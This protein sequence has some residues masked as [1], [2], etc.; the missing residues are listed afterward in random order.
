MRW[1]QQVQFISAVPMSQPPAAAIGTTV[2]GMWASPE[3]RSA[4]AVATPHSRGQRVLFSVPMIALTPGV[5]HS[6]ADRHLLHEVCR[7]IDGDSGK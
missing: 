6:D 3:G 1:Y 7:D 2:N 5:Y 4:E